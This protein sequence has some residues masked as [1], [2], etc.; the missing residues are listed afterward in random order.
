MASETGHAESTQTAP[1][2]AAAPCFTPPKRS[3]PA[4]TSLILFIRAGGRC[5]REGCNGR[6]FE[7]HLSKQPGNYADRSH[8]VAFSKKGSRG[9]DPARPIDIHDVDNLMALCKA[10]HKEIDDH[11]E[12]FSTSS[13]KAMKEKHERRVDALLD[14]APDLGSHLI[15]FTAPIRGFRVEIPRH[16]MFDA[17]LPRHPHD[18]RETSIDLTALTGLGEDDALLSVGRRLIDQSL[19]H[20]Y[21]PGGPVEAAGRVSLFAIGPIPLLAYLGSRLG[22][23]VPV[24]LYQRHRDT[25][26]W[27][28]KQQGTGNCAAYRLTCL[29]DRG[30]EAPVA[31]LVSLS[32]RISR[33]TLPDDIA[34]R[35]TLYEIE[36][37]DASPTP[38][39]LSSADDLAAFRRFWHDAQSEIAAK[40]G[41]DK[42]LALLPAVPAPIA[43]SLGKDRL[44]KA[45]APLQIFDNDVAKGGFTFQLEIT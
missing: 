36:L 8:I 24:D 16:D 39:F 22:D 1:I 6:L 19:D 30:A 4:K 14:A 45:R 37:A 41:D 27:S 29:E 7:H 28:W 40:H 20:A 2:Q 17:I 25:E 34:S 18:G 32:G 5:E 44:P 33:E 11:P 21:G 3:I 9:D 42:P 15:S 10:C 12:R 13:L 38:T 43:V 35:S 23:K 26:D 31:I